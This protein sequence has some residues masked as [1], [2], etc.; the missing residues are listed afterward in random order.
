MFAREAK[1]DAEVQKLLESVVLHKVDAEKG[2]GI[3]L[4]KTHRVSGYPTFMLVNSD[5]QPVDRWMGYSKPLLRDMMGEAM[6]DLSTIQEKRDRLA[7]SPTAVGAARLARYDA[8][9]GEYKSAVDLYRQ[10]E[11]LDP[12]TSQA[13]DIFDAMVTG[14]RKQAFTKDDVVKAA[15][16]AMEKGNPGEI[17]YV[18]NMMNYVSSQTNDKELMVRYV[19]IAVEKTQDV[20]DAEVVQERATL[21]PAYALHVEKNAEKAVSLRRAGMP[22]GWM[23]DADQLNSYAW[24]AF[25]NQVDLPEALK[26]ARKGVELAPAGKSKAAVLDTAAELC[27]ALDNCHEAIDLTKL[28]IENDPENPFYKKQ[29]ERFQAILA[30]KN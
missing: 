21:L 18:A 15:D 4:A 11:A 2:E 29:L 3:E 22:A 12:S 26:L 16:V 25:E 19:K 5:L 17:L 1:E 6:S 27:N 24:W 13:A 8:A 28:A 7:K 30:E 14:M 9:S 10:A 23:E 20:T